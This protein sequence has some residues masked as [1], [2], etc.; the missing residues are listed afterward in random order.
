LSIKITPMELPSGRVGKE[1]ECRLMLVQA[2]A[3]IV[4]VVASGIAGC[5]HA[6]HF[7]QKPKPDF[8][9]PSPYVF[10]YCVRKIIIARIII[11]VNRLKKPAKLM[12][13]KLGFSRQQPPPHHRIGRLL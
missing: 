12:A 10:P 2:P 11:F 13:G 5:A 1:S 4:T 6:G 8:H 7:F 3:A 9:V